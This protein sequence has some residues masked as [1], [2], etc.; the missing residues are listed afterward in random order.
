MPRTAERR[1]KHERVAELLDRHGLE[2]VLLSRRCNFAWYTCGARNYVGTACDVGNSTLLVTRRDGTCVLT[3]SIEQTRLRDEDLKG[4]DIE[5]FGWSYADAA[6]RRKVLGEAIGH[7]QVA[8]DVPLPDVDA[9]PLPE[10][11]DRLRWTLTDG[12]IERYRALAGDV[13]DAV[14]TVA[15]TVEPGQTEYEVAGEASRE[16][17]RRG[18]LPWVLLVGADKRLEAHRH[19]LPTGKPVRTYVMVATCAEREG[20]IAACSRLAAFEKI[21][22]E[23]AQRHRGVVTVDAALIRS[24]QPGVDARRHLRRGPEGLR[25][26]RVPGPMAIPSPGR[27]HRLPAARGQGRPGVQG[28]GA[29]SAGVCVEPD[30]RRHEVRGHDPLPR[31]RP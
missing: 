25:H 24:T 8:A 11:F 29:R 5:V 4:T 18:C 1:H 26:G 12:E 13:T 10:D 17:V 28:G 14:E 31:E 15:R 23:L 9:E 19:P 6:D 2:G 3:T 16:L 22:G 30:D 27:V 21:W 20:L 7:R